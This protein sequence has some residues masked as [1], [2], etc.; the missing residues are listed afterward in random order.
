MEY[1]IMP[2]LWKSWQKSCIFLRMLKYQTASIL[3]LSNS[4]CLLKFLPVLYSACHHSANDILISRLK[5]RF[6][7]L[8]FCHSHSALCNVYPVALDRTRRQTLLISLWL[9]QKNKIHAPSLNRIVILL[10]MTFFIEI[11]IDETQD[12][13]PEIVDSGPMCITD[14]FQNKYLA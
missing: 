13:V 7:T 11:V 4:W 2:I 9:W 1:W 5:D 14:L 3:R 12:L 6:C 10:P 8:F